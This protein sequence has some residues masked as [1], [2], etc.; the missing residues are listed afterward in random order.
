MTLDH[1]LPGTASGTG[2]HDH[3]RAVLDHHGRRLSFWRC[4]KGTPD[5]PWCPD[6]PDPRSRPPRTPPP[7]PPPRPFCERHDDSHIR[8]YGKN[9]VCRVCI[10]EKRRIER[11]ARRIER[12]ARR[13]A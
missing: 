8:V 11:V 7:P 13:V 4:S 1:V 2:G 12:D 9:K 5:A 6:E 3:H 10:A